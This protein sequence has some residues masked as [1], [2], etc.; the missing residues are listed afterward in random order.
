MGHRGFLVGR[1]VGLGDV[2]VAG[3]AGEEECLLSGGVAE[4]V[5]APEGAVF[6][7]EAAGAGVLGGGAA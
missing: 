4:G 6:V 2:A 7:V 1:G 5:G 3:V